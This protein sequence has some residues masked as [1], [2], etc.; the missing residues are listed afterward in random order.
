[1]PA[2]LA[3]TAKIQL[4][5]NPDESSSVRGGDLCVYFPFCFQIFF[6]V[7]ILSLFFNEGGGCGIKKK[8]NNAK[9]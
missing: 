9:F 3:K 7:I 6:N 2:S 4:C 5:P 1:M 8:K